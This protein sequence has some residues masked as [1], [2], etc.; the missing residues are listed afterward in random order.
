M[1]KSDNQSVEAFFDYLSVNPAVMVFIGIAVP[2]MGLMVYS[3]FKRE[4]AVDKPKPR[5]IRTKTSVEKAQI[6]KIR[7]ESDKRW[8]EFDFDMITFWYN[9]IGNETKELV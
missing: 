8:D 7:R 5:H 9:E 4:P 6:L 1:Y 2:F 3:A